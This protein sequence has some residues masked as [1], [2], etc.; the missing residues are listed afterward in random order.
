MRWIV[1]APYDLALVVVPLIVATA[2][3]ILFGPLGVDEPMW[4]YLLCFV[5]FDVAHVWGTAYL[6]YF[7]GEAF[8]ARKAL[9][10]LSVPAFF[11]GAF[12]LYLASPVWFWTAISYFAIFHFAKQQ[13]GF[14]A[15]YKAKARERDPLDYRLDKLALWAG[16]IGPVL[17]WHAQPRGQFDWWDNGE[18]FI[19]HLPEEAQL[20]VPGLMALIGSLWC[21]RQAH[22]WLAHGRFNAGKVLWMAATWISWSIG[23]MYADNLLVSAAFLNLMH[24]LP[25]LALVWR[26]G[27]ARFAARPPRGLNKVFLARSWLPFYGLVFGIALV[28]EVLWDGL[29]WR[30]YADTLGVPAI[31][32]SAIATAFWVA[33]LSLPQLVHYFLDAFLWKLNDHND[34]LRTA[35]GIGGGR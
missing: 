16:A 6:T 24:G 19:V 26:R 10:G 34:D 8:R 15:I 17:I 25:F 1:S 33:L 20:V 29:I 30:T 11:T 5:A 35:L 21:V 13:Y 12:A 31:E 14:V 3:L 18:E 2:A 9:Y 7:D 32:L 27:K 4:A 28:E 23:L 22:A